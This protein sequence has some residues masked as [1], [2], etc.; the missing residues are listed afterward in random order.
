MTTLSDCDLCKDLVATRKN[1]VKPIKMGDPIVLFIGEA[2]GSQE[3]KKGIPFCG[4][5]G[6]WH[7]WFANELGISE[8]CAVGNCINC[9]PTKLGERGNLINGKPSDEH[10]KNCLIWRKKLLHSYPYKLVILYGTYPVQTLLKKEEPI[11]EYVGNFYEIDG[12]KYFACYHP[13]TLI[14]NTTY[15]KPI[16]DSFITKIK[17]T[18]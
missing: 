9:R 15:Y 10:I 7:W 14:Y 5:A 6:K 1:V 12:V 18:L 2:P 17:E 8:T 13:A 16:W 3:D 4:P 11:S